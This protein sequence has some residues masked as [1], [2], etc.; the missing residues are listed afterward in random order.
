MC[1]RRYGY[2][3][4]RTLPP[5][6]VC[7]RLFLPSHTV[8]PDGNLTHVDGEIH[9]TMRSTFTL[10]VHDSERGLRCF[11]HF[12]TTLSRDLR[13]FFKDRC[14]D[15]ASSNLTRVVATAHTA[16]RDISTSPA[17]VVNAIHSGLHKVSTV[18]LFL[19][20]G[21]HNNRYGYRLMTRRN[22]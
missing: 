4:P 13:S 16:G 2:V 12:P 17:C 10:S 9:V 20:L 22:A 6:L 3:N 11:R 21:K 14:Q 7:P 8:V 18:L 15:T 5:R 1:S 19:S